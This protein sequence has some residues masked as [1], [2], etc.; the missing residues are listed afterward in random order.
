MVR[1]GN[2]RAALV[3]WPLTIGVILSVLVLAIHWGV[4]TAVGIPFGLLSAWIAERLF[5]VPQSEKPG[6]TEAA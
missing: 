1:Y 2:R 6:Q 5:P 3:G 4:D